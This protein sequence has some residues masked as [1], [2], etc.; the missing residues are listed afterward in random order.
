MANKPISFNDVNSSTVGAQLMPYFYMKKALI[1][2]KE[3]FLWSQL[4][5]SLNMPKHMGKTI[6]G[7]VHYPLIDDRNLNDQGIDAAGKSTNML[8]VIDIADNKSGYARKRVRGHG[9]NAGAA[10]TDAKKRF[11]EYCKENRIWNTSYDDTKTQLEAKGWVITEHSAVPDFGNFW[12]SSKDIGVIQGRYPALSEQGGRVNR[13]GWTRLTREATMNHFGFFMEYTRDS[14]NFDTEADLYQNITNSALEAASEVYEKMIQ[15][16]LLNGA[17]VTIYGGDATATSELNEASTLTYNMLVRLEKILNDTNCPK[18]TTLIKGSSLVDTR[19]IAAARYIYIGSELKPTLY[20][21]KDMHDRPA[22]VPVHQ[23]ADAGNI[24][25]GEIGSIGG[26][27][28]IEVPDM[29]HWGGAGG[30]AT[31]HET[32]YHTNGKFD[33]FPAIVVGSG[34]FTTIGFQG[35]GN[36]SSKFEV[37]SKK[38]GRETAGFEDPYGTKGFW[39]IQWWYGTLINRP[40]HIAVIKLTAPALI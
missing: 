32:F 20:A 35:G 30:D 36:G 40:E 17:G 14:M 7:Y 22:F 16:D 39:S 19:T 34:A 24:A 27:R 37:I 1:D 38:P 3:K 33:V 23:Y 11:E 13:V 2:V 9:A 28:F 21:M 10:L 6:K 29:V 8:V 31:G 25:K 12:G 18:N 15:I 5:N 26:F 4:S